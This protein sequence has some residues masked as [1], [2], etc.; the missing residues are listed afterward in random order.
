MSHNEDPKLNQRAALAFIAWA[1]PDQRVLHTSEIASINFHPIENPRAMRSIDRVVDT[2][3]FEVTM[4]IRGFTVTHDTGERS[5]FDTARLPIS[6]TTLYRQIEALEHALSEART[7]VAILR[8][9]NE[10]MLHAGNQL[11]K[12]LY[13]ESHA[14]DKTDS[15]Y[16]GCESCAALG[17][18]ASVRE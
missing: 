9:D 14:A 2:R 12:Q 15:P 5:A 7:E 18:W 16:T 17:R 6:E 8:V 1:D 4:R 13:A 3:E 10:Q 11:A